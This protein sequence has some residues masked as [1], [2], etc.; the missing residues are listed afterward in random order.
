MERARAVRGTRAL[1]QVE[2]CVSVPSIGDSW[3][4]RFAIDLPAKPTR[5]AFCSADYYVKWHM[6]EQWRSAQMAGSRSRIVTG[7]RGTGS[8]RWS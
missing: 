7:Y 2:R 4:D 3:G 5:K 8:P 1:S 6:R